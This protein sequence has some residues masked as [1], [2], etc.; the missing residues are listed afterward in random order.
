MGPRGA[1]I[2]GADRDFRVALSADGA[3][4]YFGTLDGALLAVAATSGACV[5]SVRLG[6][7][8][9]SE[10]VLTPD[11]ALLLAGGTDLSNPHALLR[12]SHKLNLAFV[13]ALFNACDGEEVEPWCVEVSTVSTVSGECRVSVE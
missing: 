5:W 12:P 4:L 7:A 2:V 11:G 9:G 6:G 3:V 13:A 10:S 1:P 8:V